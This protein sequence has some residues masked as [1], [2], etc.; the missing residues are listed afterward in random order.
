MLTELL[1]I[2]Q[3]RSRDRDFILVDKIATV[4][5]HALV[6]HGTINETSIFYFYRPSDNYFGEQN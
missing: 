1:K 2:Y 6:H 4:D 3:Q 5:Q